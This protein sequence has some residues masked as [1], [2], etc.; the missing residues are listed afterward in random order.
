[1]KAADPGKVKAVLAMMANGVASPPASS[2]GRLFDAVSFLCG[3]APL[4][5]EYEAEAAMR[6]EDAAG[7]RTAAFYPFDVSEVGGPRRVSFAPAL[8][9]I[10][11]DLARGTP[12]SR[13]SAKFH[14]TL[15]RVI[16]D[17]ANRARNEYGI[18][19][20][21]LAG[22]CFLNR[23]LLLVAERLL[24]GAGF[25]VLRSEVY[26]PND[27]SVSVGQIAFALARARRRKP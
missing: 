7:R 27:E 26:S 19:I 8:R 21:S 15:G 17:I 16:L 6:L 25:R 13:V 10:V 22:G 11:A 24:E 2:C 23:R 14:E 4:E 3:L 1:L 18:G 20:V 5:T 9:E 12:V